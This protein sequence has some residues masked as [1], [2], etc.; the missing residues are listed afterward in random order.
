LDYFNE[1]IHQVS[2]LKNFVDQQKFSF[3]MINKS[4]HFVKKLA[5]QYFCR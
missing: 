2:Q 4:P 3:L 5:L 1:E